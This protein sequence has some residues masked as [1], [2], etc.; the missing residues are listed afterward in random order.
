MKK[1]LLLLGTCML[2]LIAPARAQD[3]GVG[4]T[5]TVPQV[6]PVQITIDGERDEIW[7]NAAYFN[8]LE[9]T[10]WW[11]EDFPEVD[12]AEAFANVMYA[13]DTLYVYVYID[14]IDLFAHEEGY[15]GDQILIGIDP[16]HEAGNTDQLLDE[17]EYAGWPG[18]APG[19]GP[20]AY[21]IY[22]TG[23]GG[24][25][26][27]WWTFAGI[28]PVAEGWA[29]G[30]VWT[31][32]ENQDWGVEAAFYVPGLEPGSEIGFNIGGATGSD[33]AGFAYGFFS[34][35]ATVNPGSDISSRTESYG[36]LVME[37]TGNGGDGYGSGVVVQVPVVEP[38]ALV[39]DGVMDEAAW[40]A[41]PELD[42]IR[43]ASFYALVEEPDL[44]GEAKVLWSEDTLYVYARLFDNEF[45]WGSEPGM[46]WDGD[47]I[48]VGIDA[49][50]EMDV[51]FD[52]DF[53][54]G[55]ENAPGG[56]YTYMINEPYGFTFAWGGAQIFPEDSLWV[57]GAI[58][59][60][61]DNLEWGFEAA[62]YVPTIEEGSEIGFDIGGAQA[63]QVA[64][65]EEGEG[66]YGY[67]A[68]QSGPG[69]P[70]AINRDASNWATLQFVTDIGDSIEETP[71]AGIP[72]RFM[73]SQ[74]YPNPF[75]PSTT[76]EYG[77]HQAGHV[78]IDVFNL[79]GQK[80]TT[81]IDATRP[82][83]TY[84]V[85]WEAEDLSSG[86]YL[87]QLRVDGQVVQSRTMMLLK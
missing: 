5:I 57:N 12:V 51:L 61:E 50:H 1:T 16:V 34:Q 40:D 49:T 85:N 38:G 26:T 60:D 9:N 87:Y 54:G 11:S 13:E 20:Y 17:E 6:D 73:L 4:A 79:L 65:D 10:N 24:T 7:D 77:L 48:M 42:P 21:T 3:Y 86:V 52:P 22:D 74:N 43:N 32:E 55:A 72:D 68:W 76:F 75:N 35:W 81:L 25:I 2:L 70:G 23:D 62:F 14:D 46:G 27:L 8:L 84:R 15:D 31:D 69:D 59:I 58:F 33:D 36:T 66:T 82:A 83:G 18:N 67:F 47:Q 71:G 53:G 28:D 80:V 30:V 63:S 44:A 39:I 19:A 29:D 64:A 45:F 37:D 56:V 78:A 41:A